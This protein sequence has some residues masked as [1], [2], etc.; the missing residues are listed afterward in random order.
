S[1]L[2][3]WLDHYRKNDHLKLVRKML[4]WWE[5]GHDRCQKLAN[6]HVASKPAELL[7][8]FFTGV[9]QFID[10]EALEM[11]LENLQK[12]RE[13]LKSSHRQDG[14]PFTHSA[15]LANPDNCVC[16]DDYTA[17]LG[18]RATTRS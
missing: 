11:V 12:A 6:R 5:S 7:N 14:T 3:R 18:C 15:V 10:A 8:D 2:K 4:N 17:C 1:T 13:R 16:N 9:I